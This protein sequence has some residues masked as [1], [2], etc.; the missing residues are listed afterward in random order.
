MDEKIESLSKEAEDLRQRA[1][2]VMSALPE[3]GVTAEVSYMQRQQHVLRELRGEQSQLQRAQ[4]L[5]NRELEAAKVEAS[6]L[7][8]KIRSLGGTPSR[9]LG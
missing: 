5:A 7:E 2:V 8:R 9:S 4:D 6:V 3:P 1:A